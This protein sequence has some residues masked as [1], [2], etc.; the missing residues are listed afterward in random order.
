MNAPSLCDGLV[1]GH[2][3]GC[4][5]VVA[6]SADP[7]FLAGAVTSVLGW[8]ALRTLV[9]WVAR[10]GRHRR[11]DPPDVFADVVGLQDSRPLPERFADIDARL[12]NPSNYSA[13]AAC[14]RARYRE[15][16]DPDP[17]ERA[18]WDD[19]YTR[20]ESD[21]ADGGVSA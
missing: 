4:L 14:L 1:L 18:A 9:W 17:A 16:C 11:P 13:R 19:L 3:S 2:V 12:C 8:A 6:V 5:G 15:M 7:R 20:L 21:D 10:D